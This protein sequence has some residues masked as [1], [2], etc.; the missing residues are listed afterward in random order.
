MN[1]KI[2]E[3]LAYLKSAR[4]LET[5]VSAFYEAFSKKI[6]QP[7]SSFVLGFAYDSQ[8]CAKTI[9]ALLDYFD[10]SEIEGLD[11]KKDIAE[12]ISSVAFFSRK[13]GKTNNVNYELTCESLRELSGL[14]DQL[15]TMYTNYNK[16]SLV[17]A[18]S[19]EFSKQTID[20]ANFKKIF[21]TLAQ[22]KVKHK[23]T[24]LEI[25]FAY[26]SKEA[27]R[28]RNATPLVRYKNPDA[29]IRD[30]TFHVFPSTSEAEAPQT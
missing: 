30:S 29:W 24:L 20:T 14:E 1:G 17:R 8:K 25:I 18:L 10:A 6:N 16:S 9:E 7:E 21:D 3:S 13:I 22:Q 12:L 27:E 23:E 2:E 15:Y 28:L 4:S 26:E 19:D 5:I 11:D